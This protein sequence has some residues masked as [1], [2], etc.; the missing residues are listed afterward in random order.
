MTRQ[1]LYVGMTRGRHANHLWTVTD[2]FDAAEEHTTEPVAP[3]RQILERILATDGSE[4]S[5]T[6]T[7]R[8]R[9][10]RAGS[11]ER[12]SAIRDTLTAADVP[13]EHQA[14]CANAADNVD[15]LIRLRAVV[16]RAATAQRA[17]EQPT[18]YRPPARRPAGRDGIGR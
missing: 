11:V 4:Q 2:R 18:P 8:T 5:A 17:T 10:N 7:L 1:A 9:Q 14:E 6:A 15:R 12:L 3:H 13:P 16:P